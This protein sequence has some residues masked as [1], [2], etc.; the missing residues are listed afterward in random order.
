[1]K[2]KE[3]QKALVQ[4][5]LLCALFSW[6]VLC[7]AKLGEFM[8][9][10]I[11]FARLIDGR[12]YVS[13]FTNVYN[14][15]VLSKECLN[16]QKL[17]VY[18]IKVQNEHFNKLIAP[19]VPEQPFYLQYPPYFFLLTMPLSLVPMN[20]AWTAWNLTGAGLSILG[21]NQL[22]TQLGINANERKKIIAFFLSSYP[23]WLTV[24]LG[25][26]SFFLLAAALYFI[27]FL[28]QKRFLAAGLSASILMI[29]LQYSPI[30]GLIGLILGRF[31]FTITLAL[32][33]L[34]LIALSA[35]VLGW[36]N[37]INYPHSLI[38]G[39]TGTAVS[40]VSA[41]M[42]QNFRGELVLFFR[43]DN[44][45]LKKL[46]VAIFGLGALFSSWQIFSAA[47]S[48]GD[49]DN[50][51]T[52][53]QDA[54][55]PSES[56]KDST[57]SDT[58]NESDATSKSLPEAELEKPHSAN[59]IEV[60]IALALILALI[61]SPHT[62]V[63]DYVLL[64]LPAVLI[65]ANLN[66]NDSR[67]QRIR[68]MFVYFVPLSWLFFYIQPLALIAYAQLTFLYWAVASILIYTTLLKSRNAANTAAARS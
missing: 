44:S 42:M 3:K 13:D 11:L 30:F 12:P 66:K 52:H 24:E 64:A 57:K 27:Y 15:G 45:L 33:L 47:K 46:V 1:M 7:Y 4:F 48:K 23:A 37:I 6:G 54:D 59:R 9:K 38:A 67:H 29:K 43:E 40:G 34:V 39:E 14:A 62:H 22:S 60:A 19:I 68:S 58:Q 5:A 32:S 18:D 16:G 49:L 10:G 26:T 21:M 28:K 51:Y 61:V 50:F 53:A 20:L 56:T 17:D 55:E 36:S 63:Q 2:D 25:Q 41:F 31:K 8:Y 35:L 65:L